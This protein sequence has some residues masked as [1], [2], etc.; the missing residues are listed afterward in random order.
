MKL[1]IYLK[2]PFSDNPIE[3]S[4]VYS[5]DEIHQKATCVL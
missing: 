2:N 3:S 1:I 5:G 4:T